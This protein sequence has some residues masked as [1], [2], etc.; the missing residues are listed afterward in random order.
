MLEADLWRS[1]AK[2]EALSHPDQGAK[3]RYLRDDKGHIQAEAKDEVP[4]TKEEGLQR[5]RQEMEFRFL[6]GD[7]GEFDYRRVDENDDFDDQKLLDLEKQDEWFDKE[8]PSS[9]DGQALGGE[10][11]V[12]DF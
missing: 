10:T 6:R 8:M 11:G 4:L 9:V 7:D 2:V 3:F 5:W 12:Q 1:E